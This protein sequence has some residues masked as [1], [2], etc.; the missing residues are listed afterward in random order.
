MCSRQKYGRSTNAMR[1]TPLKTINDEQVNATHAIKGHFQSPPCRSLPITIGAQLVRSERAHARH[2]A[3]PGPNRVKRGLTLAGIGVDRGGMDSGIPT[4]SFFADGIPHA[5]RFARFPQHARSQ[6]ARHHGDRRLGFVR[7]GLLQQDLMK[8][9]V[10]NTLSQH[11]SASSRVQSASNSRARLSTASVSFSRRNRAL[12]SSFPLVIDSLGVTGCM[13]TRFQL[14]RS[15]TA[16]MVSYRA[17]SSRSTSGWYFSVTSLVIPNPL[18]ICDSQL[19]RLRA[20]FFILRV[21]LRNWRPFSVSGLWRVFSLL[22]QS[23]TSRAPTAFV[24]ANSA[25]CTSCPKMFFS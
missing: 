14:R 23:A 16:F 20:C 2:A 1:R 9:S 17:L 5:R 18:R 11:L 21:I 12:G 6:N 7:R 19:G 8:K 24:L 15:R 25:C 3:H 13:T 10:L 22:N 4:A